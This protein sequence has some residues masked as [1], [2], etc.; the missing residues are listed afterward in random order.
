M[1][2]WNTAKVTTMTPYH[3]F[4]QH[5]ASTQH[6]AQRTVVQA[7][8]GRRH[9]PRFQRGGCFDAGQTKPHFQDAQVHTHCCDGAGGLLSPVATPPHIQMRHVHDRHAQ[10]RGQAPG[11]QLFAF[12]KIAFGDAVGGG[13]RGRGGGRGGGWGGNDGGRG[14]G[15]FHGRPERRTMAVVVGTVMFGELLFFVQFVGVFI[16]HGG[17]GGVVAVQPIHQHA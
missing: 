3:Q 8:L 15:R 14:T 17:G 13:G 5:A 1:P 12:L 16:T 4:F 11:R 2:K 10:K 6:P 9:V 7:Q